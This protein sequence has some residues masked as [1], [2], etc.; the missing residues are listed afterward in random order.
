MRYFKKKNILFYKYIHKLSFI[1]VSIICISN[2]QS[3][4]I[5][6][7]YCHS[8]LKLLS[9]VLSITLFILHSFPWIFHIGAYFWNCLLFHKSSYCYNVSKNW[10]DPFRFD[11]AFL[12]NVICY[13]QAIRRTSALNR[14]FHWKRCVLWSEKCS[15]YYVCNYM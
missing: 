7:N 6:L 11:S 12:Q 13:L 2:I 4:C 8:L 10:H 14:I 9:W 1:I 3:I 15:I 5:F